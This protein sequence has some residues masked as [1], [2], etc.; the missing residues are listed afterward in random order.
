M[1]IFR[2]LPAILLVQSAHADPLEIASNMANSGARELA[3]A[4]ME[5]HAPTQ[6]TDA[7]NT[8][9]IG[10]LSKFGKDEKVLDV[11]KKL[12]FSRE[13]ANLAI[14][15]AFRS[16]KPAAARDWLAQLV[17]KGNLSK[18]ALRQARLQ[19]IRSHVAEKDGKSAYYAMLRFEQDYHPVSAQEA[20]LFVSGLTAVGMAKD[21]LSWLVQLDDKDPVKVSAEL[22]AGLLSPEDAIK[23]SDGNPGIL[24]EAAKSGRDPSIEIEAQETLLGQGKISGSDLWKSYLDR[25]IGFSNRYSLL[26]GNYASW[27]DSIVKI[28]D[29]YA[30]RSLLA[31]LSVK[32]PGS[33]AISAIVDS[34]KDQPKIAVG[35]FRDFPGLSPDARHALGKTAL[36]IGNYASCADFWKGIP[37]QQEE[38]PDLAL[39]LLK[40]GQSKNAAA[41]LEQYL[42][43]MK[44]LDRDASSRM[45]ALAKS[46]VE[47]GEPAAKDV[48]AMLGPLADPETQREVLML[49]GKAS[50]DPKIAAMY[51]FEAALGKTDDLAIRARLACAASLKKAG[52]V[53]DAKSQYKWLLARVK[54]PGMIREIRKGL[55]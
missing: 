46:L 13:T 47:A 43:D 35:L 31:Y 11:A 10:L 15:S 39:A 29:P 4:Y 38:L 23:A 20:R 34:L 5:T 12:P 1:L 40:S 53:E 3:L 17:W 9:E 27:F 41:T 51:Y 18:P 36:G 22:Q 50:E 49:L 25:A 44:A 21:G 8:L 54:E 14:L 48:L 26:Q 28:P 24:V 16:G 32:L 7:W 19:V 52:F 6:P 42:K 33:A 2:L 45:L 37:L 30:K 55:Q